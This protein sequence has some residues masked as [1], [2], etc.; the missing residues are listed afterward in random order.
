[1]GSRHQFHLRW[2]NY[3]HN[4][5]NSF[6][7]LFESE[8]LSDVTL[9]C[10]GESYRAHRVV[11]AASSQHFQE[12]F[13]QCSSAR[14]L[15]VIL[16]GTSPVNLR[17][18]LEFMYK[19]EVYIDDANLNTFLQTAKRLQV[20]GL[21]LSQNDL[22]SISTDPGDERG[23]GGGGGGNGNGPVQENL[24]TQALG[25]LL[26][27][28]SQQNQNNHQQQ[29]P[30]GKQ[31]NNSNSGQSPP[32][33][34]SSPSPSQTPP[35]PPTGYYGGGDDSKHKKK[36]RISASPKH[37]SPEGNIPDGMDYGGGGGHHSHPPR[38]SAP[39]PSPSMNSRMME[40][41]QRPTMGG[42]PGFGPSMYPPTGQLGPPPSPQSH[43]Q[44]QHSQSAQQQTI[45]ITENPNI[46]K[47]RSASTEN[48]MPEDLSIK[49]EVGRD[50]E[51]G[52]GGMT[53][54]QRSFSMDLSPSDGPPF[55]SMPGPSA[56][57]SLPSPSSAQHITTHDL[58]L[59][60]AQSTADGMA[61]Y[62]TTKN[63]KKLKCPFCE[64]LY[65]YETNLRA[66]IRQRHQGIR[67]PCPFCTRTFTRNNTVRRHVAREH[68]ALL[69]GVRPFQH[70]LHPDQVGG[71]H[72]PFGS[73]PSNN[74]SPSQCSPN[75]GTP[76]SI[77]NNGTTMSGGQLISTG[78]MSSHGHH[79]NSQSERAPLSHVSNMNMNMG[80]ASAAAIAAAVAAASAS[81]NLPLPPSSPP[82]SSASTGSGNSGRDHHG[83]E[84]AD[85]LGGG[86][87][88]RGGDAGSEGRPSSR[89]SSIG[90]KP[91]D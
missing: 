39:L 80:G 26:Q 7:R 19:G 38:P 77:G 78:G 25:P 65:G 11:L 45:V 57:W 53:G 71:N 49:L 30:G 2:S 62:H 40:I 46:R 27:S 37:P 50:E 63:G 24:L 43:S 16:D 4:L 21:S 42:F 58:S 48:T 23:S 83:R 84:R 28:P 51:L 70:P 72:P 68:R 33:S 89:T 5:A 29:G 35:N 82:L 90:S 79:M 87:G 9:F 59:E 44:T 56:V 17:A 1:M 67:V 61:Q 22:Q 52:V 10:E 14:D 66:H 73:P 47:I 15:V 91:V 20:K 13:E 6:V 54:K 3:G 64:R 34:F 8:S 12:L 81:S 18:L 88:M 60:N 75:T 86:R 31:P 69:G 76:T 74:S 41:D 55:G 85:S 36:F 32:N